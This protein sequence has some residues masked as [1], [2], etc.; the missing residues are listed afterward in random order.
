MDYR[1]WLLEY[2]VWLRGMENGVLNV[3]YG[4]WNIEYEA[5]NME[6]RLWS[7]T[8]EGLR[9]KYRFWSMEYGL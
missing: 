2:A 7:V 8:Y 4:T 1:A 9:M 3:G 6:Y 5:R